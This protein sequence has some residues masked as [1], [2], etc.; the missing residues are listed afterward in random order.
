MKR[1]NLVSGIWREW[2]GSGGPVGAVLVTEAP[3]A[4]YDVE[5]V[6][7]SI[8]RLGIDYSPTYQQLSL[9]SGWIGQEPDG[10][11]EHACDAYGGTEDDSR[12][13]PYSLRPVMFA[14]LA[15]V[16]TE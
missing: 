16:P 11:V 7:R 4:S 13:D 6:E 5:D 2:D 8:R 3:S 10:V 15:D 9:I 12:L 14:V 1:S